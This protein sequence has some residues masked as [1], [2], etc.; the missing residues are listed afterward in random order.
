[1]D[2]F[3][4]S[5]SELH[6]LAKI[7]YR[8]GI[9]T[10]YIQG[11]GGN[12]SI[13]IDNKIWVKASG[14]ELC[15]ALK[16]NIFVCL[17][18]NKSMLEIKNNRSSDYYFKPLFNDIHKPSIETAFHILMPHRV[19]IHSHSLDAIVNTIKVNSLSSINNSLAG[20]NWDII[21]Y[22]RP[23]LPLAKAIHEVIKRKKV[24]VLLLK[25][26]G[27]IIGAKDEEAAFNL[28]EKV[29]KRLQIKQREPQS[30]DTERINNLHQSLISNGIKVTLPKNKIIHSLASDRWSRT[31]ASQ[32]PIYPDH[33]VFCGFKPTIISE[34]DL[35]KLDKISFPKAP[36]LIVEGLGVFLLESCTKTTEA[37]LAAQAMVNLRIEIDTHIS[38]LSEKDC[39]E[40]T[41]WDA[42]K[43][44]ISLMKNLSI[45]D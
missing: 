45:K 17:D 34:K 38:T 26:H 15:N 36:Y 28:H 1:M 10:N 8:L 44:R 40:L 2:K 13:K 3:K 23:G 42:E 25:N 7:S 33:V 14:M 39:K 41:N 4:I 32:N 35:L 37:M 19:V 31:L 22:Y 30:L 18:L 6:E 11:A 21:P 5:S 43:Y 24:D 9:N 29:N 20:M 16:K 12:T 27:I